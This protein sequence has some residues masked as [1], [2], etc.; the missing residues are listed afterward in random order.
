MCQVAEADAWHPP[1]RI[2]FTGKT[3]IKRLHGKV[4]DSSFVRHGEDASPDCAGSWAVPVSVV[5]LVDD[6]DPGALE[7]YF[8]ELFGRPHELS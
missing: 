6:D 3:L 7:P 4:A 8:N 2:G 5:A 1:R